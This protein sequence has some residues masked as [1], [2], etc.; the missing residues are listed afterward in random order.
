MLAMPPPALDHDQCD[1]RNQGFSPQQVLI[2]LL[3]VFPLGLIALGLILNAVMQRS[4]TPEDIAPKPS[5]AIASKSATSEDSSASSRSQTETAT[6]NTSPQTPRGTVELGQS[7]TGAPIRLLMGSINA[8]DNQF[9]EFR[10]Q[11][12]NSTIEAMAN[13]T[14]Q[15]WTSYPERQVNRPQSPATERMLGLVCGTSPQANQPATAPAPSPSPDASYPGVAIVFDPPS[16][17]RTSPG[18]AFLCTVNSQRNVRVGQIQGEWYPTS[19]CGSRGFIHR[20]QV[21]F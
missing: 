15:S 16:N 6:Q 13:C 19:A 20:S 14:D 17:V 3:V 2:I 7:V 12:G 21:R 1:N 10:Y 9:R 11:L 18:G 8:R 5:P 4:Q